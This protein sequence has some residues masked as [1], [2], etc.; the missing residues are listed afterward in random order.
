MVAGLGAG[1]WGLGAGAG[2]RRL[3]GA[4]QRRKPDARTASGFAQ[5]LSDFGDVAGLRALGTVNDLELDGLALLVPQRNPLNLKKSTAIC[6][7]DFMSV[8]LACLNRVN[9]SIIFNYS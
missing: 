5:G 2:D 1:G 3:T 4:G 9:G 7:D 6:N 8:N